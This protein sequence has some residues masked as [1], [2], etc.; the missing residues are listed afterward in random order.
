MVYEILNQ[1]KKKEE[2]SFK[3]IK[4]TLSLKYEIKKKPTIKE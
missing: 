4:P 1:P 2:S 3:S